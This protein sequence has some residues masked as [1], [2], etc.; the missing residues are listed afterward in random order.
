MK[1]ILVNTLRFMIG[2]VI[3]CSI[4]LLWA[5]FIMAISLL[6]AMVVAYFTSEVILYFKRKYFT[7]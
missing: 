2:A 7:K 4:T 1:T 3:G 5:S 6:F